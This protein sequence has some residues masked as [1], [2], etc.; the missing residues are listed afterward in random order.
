MLAIPARV[1]STSFALACFAGTLCYG[2]YNENTWS[3]ILAGALLAM[4]IALI[5]GSI[6]SA[7]ALR[8][9]NEHIAKYKDRNPIPDE[10]IE[11]AENAQPVTG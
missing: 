8:S 4:F 3:S 6:L 10:N 2:I 11:D 9:V 7:V 5:V 1:I